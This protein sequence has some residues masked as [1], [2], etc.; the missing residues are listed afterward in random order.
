MA[1]SLSVVSPVVVTQSL[2]KG[3]TGDPK[4]AGQVHTFSLGLLTFWAD[5]LSLGFVLIQDHVGWL[6]YTSAV[7]CQEEEKCGVSLT[8]VDGCFLACVRGV[9]WPAKAC[10]FVRDACHHIFKILS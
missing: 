3:N 2:W 7:Q 6:V 5:F 4:V 9:T 8:L 1:H 10:L